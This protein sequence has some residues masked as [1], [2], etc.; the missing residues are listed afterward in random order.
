MNA[1][2][3]LPRLYDSC[4]TAVGPGMAGYLTDMCE[5]MPVSAHQPRDGTP[6]RET[7]GI[8]S[9]PG[10]P[11]AT[12]R[13]TVGAVSAALTPDSGH[14]PA[15][16][17]SRVPDGRSQAQEN[18]DMKITDRVLIAGTR[19]FFGADCS[20]ALGFKPGPETE[21]T[22]RETGQYQQEQPARP[23]GQ[24]GEGL[25]LRSLARLI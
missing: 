20:A 15:A 10:C 11:P 22:P 18:D 2:R 25:A 4:M 17:A 9:S 1:G 8:A 12:M 6:G 13:G 5:P 19:Q 3:I 23:T 7:F 24:P 14:A 16:H 21:T